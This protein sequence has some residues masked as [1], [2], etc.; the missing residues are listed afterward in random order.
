MAGKKYWKI[1][2]V[3]LV[4]TSEN[5]GFITSGRRPR[6]INPIFSQVMTITTSDIFQYFCQPCNNY[7]HKYVFHKI[8]HEYYYH[9]I[10]NCNIKII[11]YLRQI[12]QDTQNQILIL[13]PLKRELYPKH[14]KS[15]PFEGLQRFFELNKRLIE[16]P[17]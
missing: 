16:A 4:I 11:L 6:V 2:R 1:L 15:C 5:I 14:M 7:S 10:F 12:P 17:H 13:S 8:T 9:A 3:V